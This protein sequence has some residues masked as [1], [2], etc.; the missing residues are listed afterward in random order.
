MAN[1]SVT[2]A[3]LVLYVM[4]SIFAVMLIVVLMELA[5]LVFVFATIVSLA[6]YA[7]LHLNVAMLTVME[8]VHAMKILANV[9]VIIV[10]QALSVKLKINVARTV[11][12]V[13]L[14]DNA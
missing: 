10:L 9:F 7:I 3:G 6:H 11:L 13:V 1:V 14:M 4:K 5:T 2:N 8:M 12:I